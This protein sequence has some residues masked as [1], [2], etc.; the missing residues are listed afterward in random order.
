MPYSRE[1]YALAIVEEIERMEKHIRNW[2][3]TIR[4]WQDKIDAGNRPHLHHY[5]R[6]II[7]GCEKD[8]ADF[9]AFIVRREMQATPLVSPIL[10]SLYVKPFLKGEGST[11]MGMYPILMEYDRYTRGEC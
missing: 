3:R 7:K 4:L 11:C 8:I 5:I 10:P 1:A 6:L 2:K 9:Q